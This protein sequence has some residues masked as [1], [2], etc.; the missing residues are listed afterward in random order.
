VDRYTISIM[1][2]M[3]IAEGITCDYGKLLLTLFSL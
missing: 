2:G 1:F 3:I